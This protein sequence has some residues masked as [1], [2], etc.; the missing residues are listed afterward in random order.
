MRKEILSYNTKEKKIEIAGNKIVSVKNKNIVKKGARVFKDNNVYSAS[1]IGEID[2]D[3]LISQALGNEL[4]SLPFDYELTAP[5]AVSKKVQFLNNEFD[6]AYEVATKSLNYLT[7]NFPKFIFSG[8]VATYSNQTNMS[9]DGTAM[10]NSYDISRSEIIYKHESSTGIMDS[11]FE[12]MEVGKLDF[13]KTISNYAPYLECYETVVNLKEGKLPVVFTGSEMITSKAISGHKANMYHK[14]VGLFK[15]KLGE[16]V[17]NEKLNIFDISYNPEVS[18]LRAFDGEGF[19]REDPSLSLFE[20]GVFSNL[21]CDAR[22]AKLYNMQSTG[23]GMRSYNSSPQIGFNKVYI[24]PGSKSISEILADLPECLVVELAAGGDFT[25]DGSFSTPVQFGFLM[26]NG[27]VAG[28]LPQLTLTAKVQ[29]YLGDDL[30]DIASDSIR[31]SHYNPSIVT[32]M[33]VKIN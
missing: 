19:L 14:G 20:K 8:N 22:N 30:I 23:N 18:A 9:I 26:K 15:G 4:G 33:N 10:T 12:S 32:H 21:V 29:D 1:N 25:D 2:D 6:S 13:E 5:K 24:G 16:K 27:K 7:K 3:K 17:L 31:P 11:Y 28:R